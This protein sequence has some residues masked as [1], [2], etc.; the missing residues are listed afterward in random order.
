MQTAEF[1]WGESTKSTLLSAYFYGYLVLQVPGGLLAGK[2]GATRVISLAMALSALCTLLIPVAARNSIVTFYTLRVLIGLF[3]GS[4]N[5]AFQSL[6]GR[7]AP[8]QERTKLAAF[9]Y[10]GGYLGSIATFSVSGV[11]CDNG[12]NGGWPS[13]FYILGMPILMSH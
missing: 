9:A 11:L 3:S 4:I 6:W 1:D 2:Y 7:W 13:I 12:F 5:P 10:S 8:T